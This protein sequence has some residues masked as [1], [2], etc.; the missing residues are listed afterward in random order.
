MLL[1]QRVLQ[2]GGGLGVRV[3]VS[4]DKCIA[5]GHCV[6]RADRVFD[7]GDDDGVVVLLDANPVAGMAHAVRSA[8][9]FCPARAIQIE[10]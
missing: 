7:Q 5:S 2:E 9:E 1:R 4:R 3:A 6:A 8:A 10:D